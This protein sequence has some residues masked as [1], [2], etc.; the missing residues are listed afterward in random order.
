MKIQFI[1]ILKYNLYP[2][3]N[4][5]ENFKFICQVL[6]QTIDP[7]SDQPK[8]LDLKNNLILCSPL[9]RAR[10]CVKLPAHSRII[11]LPE[12]AEIKIDLAAACTAKE[13][14]KKGNQLIR[15]KFKEAFIQDTLPLSRQEIYQQAKKILLQYSGEKSITIVSHTFRLIL[16]KAILET[17]GQI[18]KQ[19]RLINHY[20]NNNQKI[21]TFGQTFY[22]NSKN[23]PAS[24]LRDGF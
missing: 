23:H 20:I 7:P 14:S 17:N 13:W 18:I 11:Y 6:N 3:N 5:L 16:L 22:F 2:Q 10:Q 4:F 19:P 12:L 21:L 8:L 15:Q 9:K 1:K 24:K